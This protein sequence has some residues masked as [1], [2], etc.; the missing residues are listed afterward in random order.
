MEQSSTRMTQGSVRKTIVRF[1]L[2]VFWGNLFQQLY[3]VVDSLVVGNYLGS[4]ALAAVGSSGSL[5]FLLVGLFSGIFVGA[6]VVISR[7]YGAKD[8]ERVAKAIH[9]TVAFAL[10]AGALL[11][12]AGVFLT[13][14]ILRLMDTPDSVLPNSILYFRIYFAGIMSV[15]LYNTASGIFQAVGDSRHPLYYLIIS[16]GLNIA[17]DLLFVAV[18]RWG[19]GGAALATVFSQSVSAFL[20][21]FR[22]CRIRTEYRVVPKKIRFHG[23][24]LKQVLQMGIPS[25]L[26]N[27]VIALAN[28]VVQ[29]NINAFGAKAVAGCGAYAKIEGFGFLPITSFALALT[30]FIGQNLGAGEIQRAKK[31][32]RFGI[33]TCIVLAELVGVTICLLAPYLVS[34]FNDDPEVIAFGSLQAHTVTL[35]YFLLAF[36]HCI[37]GILR[38]AGK[39]VVP[40]IVMLVCWCAVRI[41]YITLIARS[42]GQIRFIFWAYPF[43]WSLSSVCFLIYYLK[44]DWLHAF[45]RT[46]PRNQCSRR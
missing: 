10:A 15:V 36:S 4:D 46:R 8:D 19:I 16:S 29:S 44:S 18:F 17:L 45:E 34:A 26:Q 7:Y 32:A 27:S 24:M 42:T 43:T 11:T 31:G 14:Q 5:I 20:G 37:A 6:G 38:G 12:A 40:M 21:F 9:T 30:T 22:L 1:A 23:D 2:P 3:N 33:L 39:S 13:P 25:G 35:F 28:L 41:A